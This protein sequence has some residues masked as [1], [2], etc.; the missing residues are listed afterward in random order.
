MKNNY[1]RRIIKDLS[2]KAE[3]K[4]S[5]KANAQTKTKDA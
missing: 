1:A 2:Q 5:A 3:S 4:T